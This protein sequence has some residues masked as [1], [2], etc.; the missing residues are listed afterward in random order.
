MDIKSERY[1][2]VCRKTPWVTWELGKVIEKER[3]ESMI[4]IMPKKKRE[5]GMYG[6]LSSR[7]EE[8]D[9]ALRI[10]RIKQVFESTK[11]RGVLTEIRDMQGIR[12]LLFEGDGSVAVI[13]SRSGTRGAYHLA[14]LVGLYIVRKHL[15]LNTSC[16]W[17]R[18]AF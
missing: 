17:G 3:A 6:S 18:R 13:R 8:E 10:D 7:P 2:Y 5:R 11:W 4:L 9:I 14:A 16:R 15:S 12:V 1:H